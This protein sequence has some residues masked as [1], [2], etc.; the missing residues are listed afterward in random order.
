MKRLLL[1][2]PL[3]AILTTMANAQISNPSFENWSTVSYPTF[4]S[5]QTSNPSCM[6]AL[7]FPNVTYTTGAVS[8]PHGIMMKTALVGK[9]TQYA[10]A[11]SSTTIG[12]PLLGLVGVPYNYNGAINTFHG[13]YQS[14]IGPNDTGRL[15]LT[16][17]HSGNI[18]GKDSITF[19]TG[20][21]VGPNYTNSPSAWTVFTINT[22]IAT[23]VDEIIIAA[24]SSN[25]LLRQGVDTSSWLALD[26][27][28]FV[29]GS[30]LPVIPGG[31]FDTTHADTTIMPNNWNQYATG[32]D[33]TGVSRVAGHTSGTYGI[34][35]TTQP[36][37]GGNFGIS[38]LTALIST[39]SF[40]SNNGPTGGGV[41]YT[42]TSADTLYGWY[43]Y[44]PV[45]NDTGVVCVSLW[46]GTTQVSGGNCF[47]A[48]TSASS[49]TQFK[50]PF[51]A[52]SAP[53]AMRIDIASSSF[54]TPFAN[55]TLTVDELSLHSTTGVQQIPLT[56]S[57]I[58]VYPN[59]AND[60]LNIKFYNGID[61]KATVKIYDLSGKMM[62]NKEFGA[63]N[64]S[65]SMPISS[66][67][68]GMYF[69]EIQNGDNVVRNKFVKD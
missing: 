11:Y 68:V 46:N 12:N 31:S 15:W 5:W 20:A 67:P 9:D 51:H 57:D 28:V 60:V 24:V 32:L 45:G 27:L 17:K 41:P 61:Q 13:Y 64:S 8:S 7:G 66:L 3:V 26:E 62:I 33:S 16:F 65:I 22:G 37:G 53:T 44:S 52:A 40:I 54:H 39:G 14:H 59:P 23:A 10:F 30:T 4:S 38:P 63:S 34:Q 35:L 36:I 29:G 18:V 25:I 21:S 48:T 1:L 42:G 49:Y 47:Y 69:Y 50:V 6:S 55:S 19:T 56:S 43:K 58:A 2:L